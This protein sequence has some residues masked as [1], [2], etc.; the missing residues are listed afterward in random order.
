[1]GEFSGRRGNNWGERHKTKISKR[2]FC[3]SKG[4]S[5]G[6]KHHRHEEEI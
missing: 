5:V 2:D 6:E 3:T 1:M 4:I